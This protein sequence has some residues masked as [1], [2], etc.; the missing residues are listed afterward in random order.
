MCLRLL[1]NIEHADCQVSVLLPAVDRYLRSCA[2]VCYLIELFSIQEGS[3]GLKCSQ[4]YAFNSFPSGPEGEKERERRGTEMEGRSRRILMGRVKFHRTKA[5]YWISVMI[6]WI[7]TSTIQPPDTHLKAF[8]IT[9]PSD[10][11]SWKCIAPYKL[12]R[13]FLDAN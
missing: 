9:F 4:Y 11:T 12:L 1:Q 5:C 8:E 13:C 10:F 3:S 7:I 2:A 6:L